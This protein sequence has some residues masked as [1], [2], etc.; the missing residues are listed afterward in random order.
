[1]LKVIKQIRSAARL[2]DPR[3][4]MDRAERN[5][6]VGLIA[7]DP[8]SYAAMEACLLPAEVDHRDRAGRMENVFREG[9]PGAP[10]LFDLVLVQPGLAGPEGAI[11]FDPADPDAAARAVFEMDDEYSLSLPLARQF[12]AFRHE[13]VERIVHSVSRENALFSLASALPNVVPG[14][15]LL[16][17]TAGEW[18]SDTAFLTMNQVRM[19]FLV[20]AACGRPAGLA[21]QKTEVISIAAGA[22]GWRAIARELAG[23]IPLGG[24]LI[25][26]AAIAYAGTY[27]IGKGL[28]HFHNSG[29]RPTRAERRD[30]Y[31]DGY[32]RGRSVAEGLRREI[33]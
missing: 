1:M 22:L 3:E 2:L 32:R 27:V 8:A 20:A 6:T 21:E 17:W 7:A 31:R 11:A 25:P 14:F 33:A 28:A 12:P 18:A 30:L 13:V 16:P 23:K 29:R 24:G 26:K 10:P 4:V 15:L 9:D 5:L 19:A